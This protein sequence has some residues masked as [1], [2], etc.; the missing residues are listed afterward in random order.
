M[1]CDFCDDTGWK[2]VTTDGV[3]RV[4]RCDCWLSDL[5]AKTLKSSG[6]PPRYQKCDLDSFR[7]YNDTL[8]RAVTKAKALA[9]SFPVVEKGLLFLGQPGIGKTHLA[10]GILRRIVQRTGASAV[11]Y[12]TRTLL[13]TIRSTYN[14]VV[15]TTE[16]SVIRPV[17]EAQFLVLD[18]LGAERPSE[19]V[20]ETMNLIIN[21][22][23]NMKRLTVFTSN[24]PE[25][26]KPGSHAE[27]LVERIGARIFSRLFEMCEFVEMQGVHFR[28]LHKDPT[29]EEILALDKKGARLQKDVGDKRKTMLRA[30]L[31]PGKELGWTG[32]KA[33]T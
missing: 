12:D 5:A 2:A 20:E 1:P 9:E 27:T 8:V 4:V 11:F 15:K 31:K 14:A 16:I 25:V 7:D 3:R 23:Y 30:Q 22:R 29:A 13:S 26:Q 33:S 21:T 6:I 17:M 18:D 19:W 32:G 28:E 10:V 24:Y